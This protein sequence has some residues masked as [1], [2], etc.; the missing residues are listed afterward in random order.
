MSSDV[1]FYFCSKHNFHSP[2]LFNNFSTWWIMRLYRILDVEPGMVLGKSLHDRNNKL[3]LGAGFSINED[4]IQKLS[5][6]GMHYLYIMEEGTEDVIPDDIITMG[7]RLKASNLLETIISKINRL[8]EF[9]HIG[10]EQAIERLEEGVLKK[11]GID[12]DAREVITDIITD[13]S[14]VKL[15]VLKSILPKS[16][17]TYFVDHAIN[18]AIIAILIGYKYKLKRNDL[19]SI[20]I[21]SFFHD[22]GKALMSVMNGVD[23]NDLSTAAYRD[24][25]RIGYHMLRNSK[26][27]TPME[28][29][30][31]NQHHEHQDGTGFPIGLKGNNMPPLKS[32]HGQGR[33][34]IFRLA[35]IS[36]IAG[37]YDKYVMNPFDETELTP[38]ESIIKLI[39][40]A[41]TVFNKDIVRNIVKVIPIFPV[42]A[43]IKI[44]QTEIQSLLGCHGV[45]ADINP[46]NLAKPI[47]IL[48][49]NQKKEK[50]PPIQINTLQLKNARYELVL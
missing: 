38:Q 17:S 44:T 22:I 42:G 27:I 10:P 9:A 32:P 4:M 47:I 13:I 25:P 43:Y 39:Q 41:G 34:K 26:I 18:S 23:I 33:G 15:K 40:N 30:I 31:V 50:I 48:Y 20:G 7:V 36:T 19:A 12:F 5:Y 6:R 3:L 24:H 2:A 8:H 35:E 49:E 46:D 16:T 11:A 45:V 37:S 29:Q 28:S 14:Y 1:F 21:G